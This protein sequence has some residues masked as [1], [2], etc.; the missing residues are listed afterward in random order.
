LKRKSLSKKRLAELWEASS[1]CYNN[2]VAKLGYSREIIRERYL[3]MLITEDEALELNRVL[4]EEYRK[5]LCELDSSIMQDI[6]TADSKGLQR[7]AKITIES[8]I[9][10]L[11]ERE[12]NNEKKST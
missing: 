9:N 12:L 6:I 1:S 11:F 2:A 8:M 7:R 5:G 10:E 4:D 3:D